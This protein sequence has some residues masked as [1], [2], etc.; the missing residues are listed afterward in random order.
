MEFN[1]AKAMS[2]KWERRPVRIYKMGDGVELEKVKKEKD[3]GVTMEENNLGVTIEENNLGVTMEENNQPV[4][5]IDK[6]FR[7]TYNLLRNI[8]LAFHY[9]D[10][11]MMKELISTIIRPRLE[12]AGVVWTP[13]K[14]KHKEAGETTKN[15]YK[16]GSRI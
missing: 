3:L 9:M 1:V 10:K 6:I 13:H 8:E 12:N 2:W 7:E 14:K 5:H 4:S 16:N 15:G 11:E